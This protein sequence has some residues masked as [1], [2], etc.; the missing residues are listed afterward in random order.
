LNSQAEAYYLLGAT[1]GTA[2]DLD[3]TWTKQKWHIPGSPVN[4]KA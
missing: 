4:K 1:V 3:S 2:L